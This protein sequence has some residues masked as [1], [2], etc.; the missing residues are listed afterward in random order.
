MVK[1]KAK[2]IQSRLAK[3]RY[4][5]SLSRPVHLGF[6]PTT[7]MIIMLVVS[8]LFASL[9]LN[10]SSG[11]KPPILESSAAV[12]V[13]PIDR[14]T[15]VV[16]ILSIE[17]KDSA[18]EYLIYNSSRGSGVVRSVLNESIPARE[19]GDSGTVPTGDVEISA[20]FSDSTQKVVY[21]GRV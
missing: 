16:T 6:L 4:E 2:K 7:G 5:E 14:N 12:S 13:V 18:I 20:V 8:V 9:V 21:R 15:S 1:P 3:R 17:P 10:W 19:V 11:I